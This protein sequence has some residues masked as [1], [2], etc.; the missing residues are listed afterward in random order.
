MWAQRAW[1][2]EAFIFEGKLKG[3]SNFEINVSSA[4]KSWSDKSTWIKK[5]IPNS[6]YLN[7]L[8]AL[9]SNDIIN[10]CEI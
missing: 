6:V 2:K 7:L 3:T 8:L 4:A 10:L 5:E 9:E 1:S